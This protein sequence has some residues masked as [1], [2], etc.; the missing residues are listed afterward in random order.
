MLEAL[1]GPSIHVCYDPYNEKT[2]ILEAGGCQKSGLLVD[3]FQES[4]FGRLPGRD[5]SRF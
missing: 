2:K 1:L 5:V 4:V 3:L